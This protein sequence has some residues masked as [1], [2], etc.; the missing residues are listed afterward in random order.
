MNSAW[1]PEMLMRRALL[2]DRKIEQYRKRG[3][4]DPEYRKARKE[5]AEK[6]H[7]KRSGNFVESDGRMIYSPT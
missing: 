7:R 2:T 5:F 6:K 1:R 3:F 4:Y